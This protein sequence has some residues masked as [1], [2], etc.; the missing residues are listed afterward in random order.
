MRFEASMDKKSSYKRVGSEDINCPLAS[1]RDDE[2]LATSYDSP[3]HTYMCFHNARKAHAH[4]HAQ[5]TCA[6]IATIYLHSPSIFIAM[7]VGLSGYKNPHPQIFWL[8]FPL[9]LS[10]LNPSKSVGIGEE[11]EMRRKRR[12]RWWQEEEVVAGGGGGREGAEGG[13]EKRPLEPHSRPRVQ[14]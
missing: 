8:S 9:S 1:S 3:L 7:D 13:K 11:G 5:S 10:G 6:S 2:R 4:L 12:G 14:Q